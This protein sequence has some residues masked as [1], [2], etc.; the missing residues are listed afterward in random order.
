VLD[1]II[2][3]L[4]AL[5]ARNT[6]SVRKV[7]RQFSRQLADEPGPTVLKLTASATR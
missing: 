6:A 4:D 1:A 5:P 3:A 2:T 7:R